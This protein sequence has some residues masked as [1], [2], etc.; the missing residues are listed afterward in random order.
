M[1][2]KFIEL[3]QELKETKELYRKEKKNV[4]YMKISLVISIVSLA[5][6]IF[7]DKTVKE[8]LDDIVNGFEM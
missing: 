3:Q 7:H 8:S 4:R 6:L 1:E 2:D 5:F